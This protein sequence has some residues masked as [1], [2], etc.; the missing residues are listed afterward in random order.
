MVLM[1]R[2]Y[3]ED[4][5]EPEFRADALRERIVLGTRE[6]DYVRLHGAIVAAAELHPFSV[7]LESIYLPAL[8]QIGADWDADITTVA[9]EHLASNAIRSHLLPRT[10]SPVEGRMRLA[11]MCLPG[12]QHDIGL[13]GTASLLTAAD[14]HVMM[15]GRDTPLDGLA[16]AVQQIEAVAVVVSSLFE[17]NARLH[18]AT[19]A[20][21]NRTAPVIVGG[22]GFDRILATVA[23]AGLRYADS[24]GAALV[25]CEALRTTHPMPRG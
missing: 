10:A 14:W 9:A 3:D 12:E 24:P 8:V 16:A 17:E 7:A 20:E 5:L 22:A 13:I 6:T 11:A 4:T 19:L 18:L 23:G 25:L 15:L 21:L 2:R 1:V